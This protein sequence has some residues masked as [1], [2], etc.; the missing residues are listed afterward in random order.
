[1]NLIV[2]V[3]DSEAWLHQAPC[4]ASQMGPAAKTKQFR[5]LYDQRSHK[6]QYKR[7]GVTAQTVEEGESCRAGG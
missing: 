6:E 2:G 3:G 7:K 5:L 1:M 4:C